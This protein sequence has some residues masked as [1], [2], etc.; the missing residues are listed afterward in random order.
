M[1]KVLDLKMKVN[2]ENEF[3]SATQTRK[4]FHSTILS[5]TSLPRRKFSP[6]APALAVCNHVMRNSRDVRF[7]D[8]TMAQTFMKNISQFANKLKGD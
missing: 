1:E 4:K 8:S 6:T 7:R 2:A 5:I 3:Y